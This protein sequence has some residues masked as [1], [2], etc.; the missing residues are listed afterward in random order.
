M[1]LSEPEVGPLPRRVVEGVFEGLADILLPRLCPLCARPLSG[2][3]GTGRRGAVLCGRCFAAMPLIEGPLCSLCG[4]PFSSPLGPDR[5]CSE[6][7]VDPPPYRRA[8]SALFYEGAALDAL[9]LF[10]YR[11]RVSLAAPLAALMAGAAREAAGGGADVVAA[12]PLH[13]SR[14]RERGFN[15]SLLLARAVAASMGARVDS[16]GLVRVAAGRPQ[17]G[18]VRSER[19]RNVRGAFALAAPGGFSGRRV[20]LV[21]DVFT[22]GSTVAECA[23]LLARAGAEVSVAT[24]A[25]AGVK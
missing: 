5:P 1:A 24:L 12:V 16:R 2:R 22:T 18:L 15:Q 8:R 3:E 10:K 13:G 9:H 6:C 23:R 19:V 11:G 21:D 14:L 7:A 17:V 25:R 20:L 4:R